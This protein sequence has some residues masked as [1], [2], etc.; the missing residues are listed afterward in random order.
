MRFVSRAILLRFESEIVWI[1][2]TIVKMFCDSVWVSHFYQRFGGFVTNISFHFV[3]VVFA[4]GFI[5]IPNLIVEIVTH[6]II[7]TSSLRSEI[8]ILTWYHLNPQRIHMCTLQSHAIGKM[9]QDSHKLTG[10][11]TQNEHNTLVIDSHL[12]ISH[13]I[14]LSKL[15]LHESH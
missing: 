14:S 10:K 11:P 7:L 5:S 12:T 13:R 4:R 15:F 3:L 8:H 1:L 6:A 2:S 9:S